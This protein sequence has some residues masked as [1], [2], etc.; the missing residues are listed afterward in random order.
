MLLERDK[1]FK[2]IATSK[3][4]EINYISS[5]ESFNEGERGE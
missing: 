3:S 1:S 5:K 4:E 2:F